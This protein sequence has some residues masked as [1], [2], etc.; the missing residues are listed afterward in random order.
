MVGIPNE[1]CTFALKVNPS[2]SSSLSAKSPNLLPYILYLAAGIGAIVL[3]AAIKNLADES[4]QTTLLY[5]QM[6]SG[7]TAFGG[8]AFRAKHLLLINLFFFSA[9]FYLA[10]VCFIRSCVWAAPLPVMTFEGSYADHFFERDEL[11][12]YRPIPSQ[13]V[14]AI[15]LL[16]ASDT[17][18]D[19]HYTIDSLS[20]RASV[21]INEASDYFAMFLGCSF[22][23]GEG[24]DDNATL[25]SLSPV[26]IRNTPPTITACR[27]MAATTFSP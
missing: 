16:G 17:L 15:R 22:V 11:F 1:I 24:L 27:A 9:F 14:S 7:I 26:D 12:G 3:L 19:V 13:R 10:E 6:L 18:Y 20:R 5:L 25:P 8:I 21:P 2:A 4:W 23:F